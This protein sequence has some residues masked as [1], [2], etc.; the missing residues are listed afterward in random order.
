[1]SMNWTVAE[2]R[3]RRELRDAEAA[4][5]EAL[6]RQ[7]ALFSTLVTARRDLGGPSLLGQDILIR[8][9]RSQ[10]S[11]LGAGNDLARVHTGLLAIN[12]NENEVSADENAQSSRTAT[13][14]IEPCPPPAGVFPDQLQANVA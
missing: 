11:L 6:L 8:L 14:R 7:C 3:I 13:Q 5:N 10:Q 4:L 2:L 1:M 9:L 12:A